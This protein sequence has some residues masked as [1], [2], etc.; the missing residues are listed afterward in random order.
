MVAQ[1]VDLVESKYV[2]TVTDYR[3]VEFSHKSQYFAL[4]VIGQLAFGE[5]LGF[6]ANDE[7]LWGYVSTNDQVFPALALMLNIPHVG[8]MMQRWPFSKLLPFSS[9]EYG[10]GKLMQYESS[11]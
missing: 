10:F 4:D 1:F 6:L 5:A 7:D 8:I 3:P 2:S 9:D 11:P